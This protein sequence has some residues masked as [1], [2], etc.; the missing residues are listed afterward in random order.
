MGNIKKN[1]LYF[2]FLIGIV[3]V[4]SC[5]QYENFTTYFNTFYNAERLIK[6]AEDEFE[7]QD[8]KKRLKPRVIIPEPDVKLPGMPKSG[9][10]PFLQEF[11]I[12]QQK[13]QPVKTK[14]DSVIIKGS[15]IL[16]KRA[17]SDYVEGSLYLIAKAYFYRREWLPSQI[18]C[19][20]L[21]DKFPEGEYV[22]D[23]FLLL[24]KNLLIQQKI[25]SGKTI[26]SRTIDIAWYKKRYDILSEAFRLQA[27][28]AIYENDLNGAGRP[29]KQAIAQVDD[30]KLKA[31][32]QLDLAL[33][34]YRRSKFEE[35]EKNFKL[36][37]NYSPDYITEF[38]A[39]LYRANTLA[40]LGKT[41]EAEKILNMLEKDGKYEEWMGDIF[42]GRMNIARISQDAEVIRTYEKKADSAYMN[43]PAILAVYFEIGMD[44]FNKNDYLNARKYFA[45]AKNHRSDIAF[46]ADKLFQL[47]NAWDSKKTAIINIIAK[48]K[49]GEELTTQ[50]STTLALNYF[51]L[52]RVHTQLANIDSS[53]MYFKLSCEISPES[54]TNT[55][56]YLYSY[57]HSIKS[58]DLA[59]A[60][61]LL[62]LL[63]ERYPRTVYGKEALVIQGYTEHFLI[64]S[65]GEFLKS[66]NKLFKIKEY[67][68]AIKQFQKVVYE[69]PES[70]YVPKALYSLGWIFEKN[71]YNKDSALFYYQWLID[72]YPDSEYAKDVKISVEYL[73]V[74]RDNKEIPKHLLPKE[75]PQSQKIIP[76][77]QPKEDSMM[78]KKPENE[79]FFDN[80]RNPQKIIDGIENKI[81]DKKDIQI[82]TNIPIDKIKNLF[83]SPEEKDTIPEEK[84]VKPK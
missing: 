29:Y 47:I 58:T 30:N 82:N 52:G 71:L 50:D 54:D 74:V 3:L 32:W 59:L 33:L 41:E 6:E 65:A 14:L 70:K 23:A 4:S 12:D 13:L 64:D 22:C 80:I 51:E 72:K 67:H 5:H 36:V 28:L 42:A 26:L 83:S 44:L 84:K 73:L 43:H 10:P 49:K 77:E 31:K 18:K 19:S 76:I 8:E 17:K 11:I 57:Y 21:I 7:Y 24:A 25:S 46:K 53:I 9:P 20:E 35:A 61:S 16:A 66:G 1:Y 39:Y 56:R 38:E 34:Y 75:I 69:F 62:E 40:R 78:I 27:E 81:L 37:H 79:Q 63:V 55:A 45:R 2:L 60:D 15:K 48:S 68:L